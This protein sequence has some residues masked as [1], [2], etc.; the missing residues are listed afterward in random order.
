[1][2]NSFVISTERDRSSAYA[3]L[4]CAVSSIMSEMFYPARQLAGT[5]RLSGAMVRKYAQAYEQ[6][7]GERIAIL[8]RDGRQFTQA[9]RETML[10]AK[11]YIDENPGMSV[12]VAM[13][14]ALGRAEI[15]AKRPGV[16]L[17]TEALLELIAPFGD[18]LRGIREALAELPELRREVAALR[19]EMERS[20]AAAPLPLGKIRAYGDGEAASEAAPGAVSERDRD[21]VLVRVARRLERLM[22]RSQ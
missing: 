11:A 16:A 14:A 2:R 7:T 1:M 5:M 17:D 18:D 10:R 9:Q 21:G 20:R 15:A 6:I 19:G 8:G 3:G 22:R 4:K 12:D 13:R